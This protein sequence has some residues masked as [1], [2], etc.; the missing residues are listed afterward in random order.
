[1]NKRY[2]DFVPKDKRGGAVK[3][4]AGT[5]GAVSRAATG[6]ASGAVKGTAAKGASGMV[7]VVKRVRTIQM[8]EP[9]I[10]LPEP[11]PVEKKEPIRLIPKEKVVEETEVTEVVRPKVVRPKVARKAVSGVTKPRVAKA[12][13]AISGVVRPKVD[14]KALRPVGVTE[15]EEPVLGLDKATET[16]AE[17]DV[18]IAETKKTETGAKKA[19]SKAARGAARGFSGLRRRK[20]EPKER[21]AVEQAL[22]KSLATFSDDPLERPLSEFADLE[23]LAQEIEEVTRGGIVEEETDFVETTE[24]FSLKQEPKFG[25]V[26]DFQPRFLDTPVEKRPLSGGRPSATA[27]HRGAVEATPAKAGASAAK[28]G[29]NSAAMRTMAAKETKMQ[30]PKAKF[31]NQNKVAKRPLSKTAYT[32]PG[33]KTVAG[34]KTGVSRGAKIAVSE[35]KKPGKEVKI[36]K[37]EKQG[38]T[39]GMVLAIVL[40]IILG[41][42]VGTVAFLLL[43]K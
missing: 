37:D 12:P 28:A 4:V 13:G 31:I 20:T 27:A 26:E 15:V 43:P 1:M 5:V 42:V 24:Q 36:K 40:T 25:V 34:T 17:V 30:I 39:I 23:E 38:G 41:A 32:E 33:Y 6:V 3:G 2:I 18:A 11:Q 8:V 9:E 7:K 21:E 14:K 16:K 35:A 19:K 29:A 22:E 10:A